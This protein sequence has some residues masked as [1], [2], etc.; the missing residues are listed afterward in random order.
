MFER[1]TERARRVV[2]FARYEASEFGSPKIEAEFL[3]LGLLREC[4]DFVARELKPDAAEAIRREIQDR[5]PRRPKISTSVDLPL[6]AESK[7]VLAFAADEAER[8]DHK[9]IGSEH[10]LLGLLREQGSFSADLLGRNG[11]TIEQQRSKL[12]QAVQ[13]GGWGDFENPRKARTTPTGSSIEIHGSRWGTKYIDSVM[14][15][16]REHS[17]HWQRCSWKSRDVVIC[18]RNGNVSFDLSLAEDQASFELAKG[19][20]KKDH[21][22]VCR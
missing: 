16:L 7:Q 10:I 5:E 22:A 8:L 3:L 14:S 21:C 15:R 18:R 6:S 20:W 12:A 1:Y 2:F 17:W 4:K 13:W 19:G 9:Y 11:L